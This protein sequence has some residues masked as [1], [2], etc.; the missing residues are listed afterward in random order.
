MEAGR[1]NNIKVAFIIQARMK[2][3]RLPGKILLPLPFNTGKP[4]I[5]WII[6]EV[7]LSAYK[8]EVIVAT[9]KNL[10]NDILSN[11]C[12]KNS[13]NCYRG[14]EENVLSRFT[15][16][17]KK[18]AFDV[19]VRLTS[20]NPLVDIS[21]LDKTITYHL[22][23][24]N[25]YTKTEGLPLGMNYEIISPSALLILETFNTSD[26]DREHVTPFI[27]NND[28]FKKD[29]FKPNIN[30]HLKHIRVT[31]DYPS[32]YLLLSAILSVGISEKL[33]GVDL[34]EKVLLDFPWIFEV[35]N[36]NIQKEKYSTL[37]EELQAASV[38]LEN[39]D[40]KQAAHILNSY[41]R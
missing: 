23:N 10:E 21:W 26:Y 11:Y 19:I 38:I 12:E 40:F 24:D 41:E 13:I 29:V 27:R 25:D 4:V 3:T 1:L 30:D 35:N 17:V 36:A 33:K 15:E 16:V 14:N 6:D 28:R 9:S 34:V 37:K 31:V 22:E 39:F 18:D 20:D 7:K 8:G 5:K 32:D 2:S